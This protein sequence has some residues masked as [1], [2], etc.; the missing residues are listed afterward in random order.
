MAYAMEAA[1]GAG[2]DF[3]VLDRPDPITASLVQGPVLDPD[4]KSSYRLL[5]RCRCAT[6]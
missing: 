2:L 4:L 6:A 5:L 3:Y 1:A